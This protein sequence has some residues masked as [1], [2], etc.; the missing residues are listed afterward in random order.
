MLQAPGEN[1]SN[2]DHK[3]I[4]GVYR[5]TGDPGDPN[6]PPPQLPDPPPWR[7]FDGGDTVRD[8]TDDRRRGETY[9]VSKVRTL[10]T[11]VEYGTWRILP[12]SG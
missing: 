2:S 6:Q 8:M 12:A 3:L 4:W 11:R 7:Q 5:G 1:P 9:R 10:P